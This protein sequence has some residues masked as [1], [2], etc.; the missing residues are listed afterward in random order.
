[1]AMTIDVIAFTV[2]EFVFFVTQVFATM[3][4][5]ANALVFYF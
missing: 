4:Q 1:M 3:K 2:N 5:N